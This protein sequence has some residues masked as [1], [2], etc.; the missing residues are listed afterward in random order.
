[1][2]A[3]STTALLAYS[4]IATGAGTAMSVRA[5]KKAGQAAEA[6][7]NAEANL[8][9]YN[10][11]V[12]DLQ[13]LDAAERGAI[14]ASRYRQQVRG[15]IGAQRASYAGQGVDVSSGTPAA[16]QA[17]TAAIGEMDALQLE[18]NAK[19]E[20]WGYQ[21]QA[22]DSRMRG[23]YARLEGVN[24]RKAG[25]AQAMANLVGGIGTGLSQGINYR[26]ARYG[27]STPRGQQFTDV[28]PGTG[29]PVTR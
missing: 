24:A 18:S 2:P 20:A 19:R 25:N 4:L 13:A 16:V 14:E 15:I 5:A 6:S 12:A 7:A 27:F 23:L 17:D 26:A 22:Y 11:S 9:D 21:V 28:L 1:M 8:D 3:F 10:A 29:I